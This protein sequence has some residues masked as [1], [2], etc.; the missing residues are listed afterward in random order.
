MIPDCVTPSDQVRLQGGVPVRA[1]WMIAE[2]APQMS[3]PPPTV[4]VTAAGAATVTFALPAAPAQ[5]AA[6]V[7][8][9]E[10]TVVPGDPAVNV[11]VA[12]VC[13]GPAGEVIVPLVMVQA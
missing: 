2:P 9:T 11:T 13:G 7:S 3:P 4:A 5:P 6:F 10:R 8:T 1:A 12:P